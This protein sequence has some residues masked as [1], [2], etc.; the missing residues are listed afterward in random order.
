MP[1]TF[2]ANTASAVTFNSSDLDKV[3]F[4]GNTVF[5]KQTSNPY[6]TFSSASSFTLDQLMGTKTWDGTLEY[7]TDAQSWTTWNGGIITAASNNGTYYLYMRGT[8][9]TVITGVADNGWYLTGEDISCDGNIMTLLDYSDPDSAV[10]A[11]KC[12]MQLFS[13]NDELIKG[14]DLPATVLSVG[15]YNGMFTLCTSLLSAPDLPAETLVASCYVSMFSNCT[16]LVNSPKISALSG[17][18]AAMSNMFNGCTSL[19]SL[20]ALNALTYGHTM[21]S[22]MF[23]GC[24]L[25]KLSTTQTGDY[26][27]PYRIPYTGTGTSGTLSFS[28]MFNNTGGTF[29]GAPTI[30]TTYYTS[31]TVIS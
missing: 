15:C 12:F 6:L 28:N 14:P 17:A 9:N 27:T 8:G 19:V 16:S 26:Q 30:N 2:N 5:E 11:D 29:T 18:N 25:I 4:N 1:I 3:T 31:N 22:S 23:A 7:S 24:S 13:S 21:C 20:P 10:M